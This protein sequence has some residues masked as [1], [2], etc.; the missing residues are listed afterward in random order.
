MSLQRSLSGAAVLSLVLCGTGCESSKSQRSQT[1][2]PPQATAPTMTAQAPPRAAAAAP[3][4][5]PAPAQAAPR[6]DAVE[7]MIRDSEREY[8]LGQTNV[9]DGH[10]EAAKAS[11]DKAMGYLMEG[12][13]DIGADERL[14]RQFSKIVENVHRLEMAALKE[15]D[16]FSEQKAEPAP[17]DEANDVTFP[18]D[19]ALKAKAEANLRGIR[20]DIPL[21]INDY[22]ASYINFFSTRGKDTLT[23]GW[24][25]AGRYQGM[26][27]RVLAEE[28]LPQDL[29][30]LAQAES[31]FHPLAISRVGAR[32]MW[33]FMHYT[34]PGYGL[35]R[36]WWVDDRQDPEKS[37]R[38]AARY[39]KDLYNQ[40]GDWYLAIAAYNSGGGNVQRAVERTGYA[41][42]WELYR[43]NVLPNETKNYVPI[44]VAITIIA[45]N[46]EQYGLS[47]SLTDVPE[48]FETVTV[49]YA[50][51]LRLVAEAIDQPLDLISELN[52]SLLRRTTPKDEEFHLKLPLGTKERYL[53]AIEA[54]P[55]DKRVLWRYHRVVPGETLS[56]LARQYKTTT[57]AIAEVNNLEDG[58]VTVDSK[59][60]IPVSGRSVPTGTTFSKTATRYKV[61]KGDT[62]LTVADDFGVPADKLRRWNRLKG[63]ALRTGRTLLIYKPV[64]PGEPE[65]AAAP[66]SRSLKG[67]QTHTVRDGDTLSSIAN[68]YGTTVARLQK[69]NGM[70]GSKIKPGD[71]IVV[72]R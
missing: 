42:F 15:G 18:V 34:A 22:V 54:V 26:I 45:K 8:Q 19:P 57:Q 69:V 68:R 1:M 55:R 71:V 30:Y 28:G 66:K 70:N 10:L 27:R 50:V 44:I 41:D 24:K 52:P 59:L 29:I 3:T 61:R 64:G 36:S 5:M 4:T 37:T 65:M 12:P 53:S 17:I 23:R 6:L 46:P 21:V 48:D 49:D 56:A 67:K 47:E 9:R 60:V 32:G 63:N 14:Q 40:F 51:D 25:R 43:R 58:E 16:G 31:G 13:V 72:H 35:K 33:Q 38:A 62:V 39:L 20:S 7:K 11:F 2:P